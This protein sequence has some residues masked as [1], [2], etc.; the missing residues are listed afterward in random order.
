VDIG[1]VLGST[2]WIL[3]GVLESTWWILWRIVW[4]IIHGGYLEECQG[5][6]VDILEDRKEAQGFG[7]GRQAGISDKLGYRKAEKADSVGRN[8]YPARYLPLD[9]D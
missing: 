7:S 3:G 8:L 1:G 5:D 2:Q 9:R 4:V 6:T